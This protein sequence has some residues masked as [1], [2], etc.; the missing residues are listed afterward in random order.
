MWQG[1]HMNDVNVRALFL[2]IINN[3]GLSEQNRFPHSVQC[4]IL[5]VCHHETYFS[6]GTFWSSDII[7]KTY[8][9]R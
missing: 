9:D 6:L 5:T 8:G 3:F 7:R 1:R 4:T 2:D